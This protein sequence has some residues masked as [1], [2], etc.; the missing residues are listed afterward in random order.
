MPVGGGITNNRMLVAREIAITTR[1]MIVVEKI[2]TL[3]VYDNTV[4][5]VASAPPGA[6]QSSPLL[7]PVVLLLF[8]FGFAFCGRCSSRPG[9]SLR[10]FVRRGLSGEPILFDSVVPRFALLRCRFSCLGRFS[11][12]V[13]PRFW[14]CVWFSWYHLPSEALIFGSYSGLCALGSSSSQWRFYPI[15]VPDWCVISLLAGLFGFRG[16]VRC[17]PFRDLLSS[18]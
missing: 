16:R 11:V 18:F 13:Q 1:I 7:S 17:H 8:S 15:F 4:L 14:L 5:V 6:S 10:G 9:S 2:I 3:K 12:S